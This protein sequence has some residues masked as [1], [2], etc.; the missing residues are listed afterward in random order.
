ML[1]GEPIWHNTFVIPPMQALGWSQDGSMF[2]FTPRFGTAVVIVSGEDGSTLADVPGLEPLPNTS[3]QLEG[4]KG[5]SSPN[6]KMCATMPVLPMRLH[7]V[8]H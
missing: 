4:S 7:M 6:G 8:H 1:A 2:M 3:P 5:L